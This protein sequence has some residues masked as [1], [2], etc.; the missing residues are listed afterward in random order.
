MIESDPIQSNSA[1]MDGRSKSV[2]QRN[3]VYV[4]VNNIPKSYRSADLRNFFSEFIE[5]SGFDCFHFRHRPEVQLKKGSDPS[6]T[7]DAAD[8]STRTG[9]TCC[10][11]ARVEED[12]VD[13]CLRMYDRKHWVGRDGQTLPTK[14]FVRRVRVV[15]AAS[16]ASQPR[17]VTRGERSAPRED[18][19]AISASDLKDMIELRPPP[20]MPRGNVGTPTK[21]FLG[22]I[23]S[24]RLPP[25]LIKKLGL[26]F[27][28]SR[29]RGLY[30][31]VPF[32]YGTRAEWGAAVEEDFVRTASGTVISRRGAP[33]PRGGGDTAASRERPAEDTRREDKE[34]DDPDDNESDEEGEEWE[35]HEALHE[36]V[37]SQERTRE[38][39]F[40]EELEVQWEKGGS[41]LVFYTDAQFWDQ[42]E[43]DFDA[44]TADDWDL[45]TSVY[46][47]QGAGDKDARDY[48]SMLH[49][50]RLRE[51]EE[52]MDDENRLASFERYTKGFGSRILEGQGWCQGQGVGR[53]GIAEPIEDSKRHPWDRS[54][55]GFHGEAL[56]RH[57]GKRKRRRGGD[58]AFI[59]TVYDRDTDPPE[60]LLRSHDST[61]V[62]F[63]KPFVKPSAGDDGQRTNGQKVIEAHK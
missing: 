18:R 7:D 8:A 49:N 21:H 12:R 25:R 29:A 16:D 58:R 3:V 4:I 44:Q 63:R 51:T 52:P 23:Q 1:K 46:Y 6:V 22:L 35:R 36:D 61:F 26:E 54:G 28:R 17:Y 5:T 48:V 33:A 24:C 10:C 9:T 30:G 55:L 20:T 34:A 53:G 43:G 38:R 47:R 27:P 45:D 62:R 39:L 42:V 41:G 56:V 32:D 50:R 13:Q 40:E 57:V 59:S 2:T 31:S 37:T 14:C 60:P 11:I 19:Q 15:T